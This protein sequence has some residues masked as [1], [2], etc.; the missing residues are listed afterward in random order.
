MIVAATTVRK[1]PSNVGPNQL[2][3]TSAGDQRTDRRGQHHT[4]Q[5]P[6]Q[7][8]PRT[9]KTGPCDFRQRRKTEA[10]AAEP[11]AKRRSKVGNTSRCGARRVGRQRPALDQQIED[12]AGRHRDHRREQDE[13]GSIPPADERDQ[14]DRQG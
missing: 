2:A 10:L 13:Q 4:E 7:H 9:G 3:K 11:A 5:Q 14:D 6:P 1:T 12:I 8:R